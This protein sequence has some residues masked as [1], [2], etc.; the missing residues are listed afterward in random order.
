MHF[1]PYSRGRHQLLCALHKTITHVNVQ[2]NVRAV[3]IDHRSRVRTT[4]LMGH[5]SAI[6][7][8]RNALE[9]QLWCGKVPSQS[10]RGGFA[11]VCDGHVYRYQAVSCCVELRTRVVMTASILQFWRLYGRQYFFFFSV[12]AA[13]CFL[14]AGW[15][16]YAVYE[17]HEGTRLS[18]L[19]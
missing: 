9:G 10:D 5:P 13:I 3:C 11:R 19:I 15:S 12:S 18:V 6:G 17:G 8:G 14:F 16:C 7:R 2:G 4:S 1:I